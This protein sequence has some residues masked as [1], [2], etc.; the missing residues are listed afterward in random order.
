MGY[1]SKLG[2]ADLSGGTAIVAVAA[3]AGIAAAGAYGLAEP[4]IA[5]WAVFLSTALILGSI[6]GQI[7]LRGRPATAA[8]APTLPASLTLEPGQF[9]PWDAVV[10]EGESESDNGALG[11]SAF[12]IPV[13]IG[14]KLRQGARNGDGHLR[15][16]PQPPA[17]ATEPGSVPIAS[18]PEIIRHHALRILLGLLV[19]GAAVAIRLDTG[20]ALLVIAAAVPP[21][22]GL[23]RA[24][25]FD[26]VRR[27]ARGLGIVLRD[28]RA[29]DNLANIDA[30]TLA[31]GG[32]LTR[33]DLSLLS[34]HPAADFKPA[35]VIAAATTC[36]QSSHSCLARAVLR[37]AVAHRVRLRAIG[38]WRNERNDAGSGLIAV[39]D[40]GADLAL[41]DRAW[42]ERHGVP[43]EAFEAIVLPPAVPGRRLIWIAELRPHMTLL[44]AL[45]FGER[46]KS[47]AVE[48]AKNLKRLGIETVLETGGASEGQLDLT[49][50]LGLNNQPVV[51]ENGRLLQVDRTGGGAS[52]ATDIDWLRFGM[53]R[54]PNAGNP[55]AEI[56]REDPRVILDLVRLARAA[57]RRETIATLL[58]FAF[59]LPPIWFALGG[60]VG[61]EVATLSPILGL[62]AVIVSAQ[63]LHLFQPTASEVDEE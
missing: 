15:I 26:V 53:S 9:V 5:H 50:Q 62:G 13:A 36:C 45:I 16:A 46:L 48:L 60:R 8:I 21:C 25:V 10:M 4:G 55:L 33:S 47:G 51:R 61:L 18:F 12:A 6:W 19:L 63:F 58:A 20:A 29:I 37:F 49:R 38:D 34:L 39:T 32:I 3:T 57:R 31:P 56:R 41:G 17:G 43:A 24:I 44:G 1:G 14:D 42:L 7:L 54:A 11:G 28:A 27:K 23:V 30:V 22:L 35:D 52:P 40:L 59:C 2:G